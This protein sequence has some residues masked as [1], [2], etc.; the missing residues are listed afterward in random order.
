M[1]KIDAAADSWDETVLVV[2]NEQLAMDN[3]AIFALVPPA[4]ADCEP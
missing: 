1:R 3:E 2:I 4:T